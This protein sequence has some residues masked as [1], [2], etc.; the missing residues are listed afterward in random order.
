MEIDEEATNYM[1]EDPAV[2]ILREER[3]YWEP[4]AIVKAT[5]ELKNWA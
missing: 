4:S 3:T 2:L 5:T 1:D